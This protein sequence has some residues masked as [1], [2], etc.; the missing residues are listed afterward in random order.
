MGELFLKS[1]LDENLTKSE[2]AFVI[3]FHAL[4]RVEH[5]EAK[6][7]LIEAIAMLASDE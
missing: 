7:L 1:N 6:R 4:A 5:K 3:L 2:V